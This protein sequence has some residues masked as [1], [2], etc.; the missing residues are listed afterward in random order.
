MS[1]KT[2]PWLFEESTRKYQGNILTWEKLN[3]EYEGT[4]YIG[5]KKL[6]Y[7]F[8]AGLIKLG[9]KKGDRV[10][11][12]AEGRKS[13]VISELAVLYTGAINVP[14]SVK[15]D[16]LS[17]LKFRMSHS[18]CRMVI[19]SEPQLHKIRKIKNDLPELEKIILLDSVPDTDDDEIT[20]E[21][22]SKLGEEY[23]QDNAKEFEE[24][25]RSIKESD[26]ANI[27]YTSGTT[28]DPKGIM[29]SHRNYTAN[30][31]QSSNLLNIPENFV[32]LLILPWDHA[33]A[34]TCG[35]YLLM[36]SGASMAS[37][38]TGKSAMDALKNIPQNI[39]EVRPSFLF[40][41]PSLAKNFKSL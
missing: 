41:V 28:A 5:I 12:I 27:C 38:Q 7:N 26:C 35:I 6:V 20:Q 15:I 19:V 40:S 29:L 16:E 31:E 39:K 23:L 21:I 13:W 25:W 36:Y 22:V 34:H 8:A 18:G 1:F 4:S 33:F 2:L 30:V 10:S 32:S 3:A 9:V 17:E 14:I 24:R 37:V 11:L